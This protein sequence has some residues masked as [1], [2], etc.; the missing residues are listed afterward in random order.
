MANKMRQKGTTFETAVKKYLEV[1]GLTSRRTCLTGSKDIGDLEITEPFLAIVEAKA[2]KNALTEK[3]EEEFRSQTEVEQ[4]NYKEAFR[5]PGDVK[6]LLITKSTGQSIARSRVQFYSTRY[7]CWV[8][9]RL[10]DFVKCYKE[11]LD[12][13]R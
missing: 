13:I 4:L 9:V 3:Q 11:I 10:G 5:I 12:D 6:G 2:Y 1:N 8:E 7:N